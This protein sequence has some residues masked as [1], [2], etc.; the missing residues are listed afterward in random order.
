LLLL[1][2]DVVPVDEDLARPGL[3]DLPE[4]RQ[5]PGPWRPAQFRRLFCRR[6]GGTGAVPARLCRRRLSLRW[7]LTGF[8]ND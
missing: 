7:I 8:A 5:G 3:P 6:P 2:A 4:V 1:D